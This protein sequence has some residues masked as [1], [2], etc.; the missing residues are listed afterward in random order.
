MADG[1]RI[2]IRWRVRFP[3]GLPDGEWLYGTEWTL[4]T[5]SS[6]TTPR[7]LELNGSCGLGLS[8]ERDAE[9]VSTF[10]LVDGDRGFRVTF[11]TTPAC[12]LVQYPVETVSLSDSG[13]ERIVQGGRL[14]LLWPFESTDNRFQSELEL[15]LES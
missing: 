15:T 7:V 5:H 10:G 4:G 6:G 3:D 9:D 8:E 1:P 12:R 2:R 13:V 11:Q 14:F